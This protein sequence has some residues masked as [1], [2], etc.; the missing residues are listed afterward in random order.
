[1]NLVDEQHLAGF[2]VGEQRHQV[3]LLHQGGPGGDPRQLLGHLPG[4]DVGECRLAQA[5]RT[6]QQ[7]VLERFPPLP[8]SFHRD[9]K[10]LDHRLLTDDLPEP[11]RA[12]G[13]IDRAIVLPHLS[14]DESISCHILSP[15]SRATPHLSN[16]SRA[17]SRSTRP[18][19]ASCRPYVPPR[20]V[21]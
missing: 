14:G 8:G 13:C 5:R 18:I 7:D 1:M 11:L 9:A 10:L 6:V 4:D 17:A 19:P 21:L 3:R 20:F 12:Q 15:C 2:E 16:H